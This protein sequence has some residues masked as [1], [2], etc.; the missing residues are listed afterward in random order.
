MT[1]QAKQQILLFVR[2]KGFSPIF[3]GK[4]RYFGGMKPL[5]EQW[6]IGGI[7]GDQ[8]SAWSLETRMWKHVTL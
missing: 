8:K 4:N 1:P 3:T 5:K 7:L 6:I 2:E